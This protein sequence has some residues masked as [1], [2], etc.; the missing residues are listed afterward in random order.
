MWLKVSIEE[1]FYIEVLVEG[2]EEN[3]FRIKL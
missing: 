2:K 1:R 3:I